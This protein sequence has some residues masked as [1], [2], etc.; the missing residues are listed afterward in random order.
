VRDPGENRPSFGS[1]VSST[2]QPTGSISLVI[3]AA[4]RRL[5]GAS[6][7]GESVMNCCSPCSSPSG[8]LAAIGWIDLRLPSSNRPRTYCSPFAR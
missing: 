8:S 2:I 5:T 7:H 3:W 6:R 1:P 4:N